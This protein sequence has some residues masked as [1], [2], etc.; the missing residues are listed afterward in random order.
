MGEGEPAGLRR[1]ALAIDRILAATSRLAAAIWLETTAGQGTNL[2]WRF[3]HLAE[4]ISL[5]K[6]PARIAVCLDTCHVFAAGYDIRTARGV[7]DT[8]KNF[9]QTIGLDRLRA[10]HVNDSKKPLGSR[11][12]RHE[13]IG[14]GEIGEEGFAAL[15]RDRR[16]RKIPFLLETPKD[17]DLEDDRINL[18]TLRRLADKNPSA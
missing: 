9:D 18:A 5:V 12:D 16:L 2:G 17:D 15:M 4:I 7:R 13:H 8:L 14:K 10:I 1:I 11:R 6:N 3:E